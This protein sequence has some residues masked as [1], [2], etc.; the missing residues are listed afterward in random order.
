LA[1]VRRWQERLE[2]QPVK[3]LGRE[4]M[5][6][7]EPARNSLGE[8]VHAP[9][10]DLAYLPNVTFGLNLLARSLPLNPGDEVL[11]TNH[12]YGACD[13][14]W[15]FMAR[16]TGIVIVRQEFELPIGSKDDFI[17]RL[18]SRVTSETKVIFLSHIT[19]STAQLFPVEAVC[20]KA[21]KAGILTIIDGAHAPGQILLDLLSLVPD[22]YL[23]N[24][25]KWMMGPKGSGFIYARPDKQHLIEPLVVSW[26]WGDEYLSSAG[27][28][29]LDLLQ[30]SGT[31]DPAPYLAVPEAIKFQAVHDW[32]GV[33]AYCRGLLVEGLKRVDELTGLPSVYRSSMD[34]IAQMG[35]ARLPEIQ[36][37]IGLQAD[38]YKNYQIEIPIYHW[39]A[40]HFI[41]LSIQGYND[42]ADINRLVHGLE[43]LL[44]TYRV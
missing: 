16:K 44:P 18:W 9:A 15:D 5:G 40:S 1:A 41:R 39:S 12:E 28:R 10:A 3:F 7:F 43:A 27:S 4:I 42:I 14:V 26:G 34:G 36:D 11:T 13:Y 21:R 17:D 33:Q 2:N 30:W 32:P 6:Y 35:I 38:L 8:Y 37:P 22:F 19:S 23:G 25:H 29:F 20:R 24:C 31:Q